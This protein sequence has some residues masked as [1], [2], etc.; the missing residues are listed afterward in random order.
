MKQ[1]VYL[2]NP[3]PGMLAQA[4]PITRQLLGGYRDID[5]PAWALERW[6]LRHGVPQKAVPW[7]VEATR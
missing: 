3:D 5:T 4:D 6:A 7:T 2:E 1:E